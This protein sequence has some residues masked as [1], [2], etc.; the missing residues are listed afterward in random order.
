MLRHQVLLA[1][2]VLS[3]FF[4]VG[5]LLHEGGHWIAAKCFGWDTHFAY[6]QVAFYNVTDLSRRS[7]CIFK[8]AG[9]LVDVAFVSIGLTYFSRAGSS[10][11]SRASRL[12]YWI[13]TALL[14][15]AMRWL[16][17]PFQPGA[18]ESTISE[19]LGMPWYVIPYA[20]FAPACLVIAYLIRIHFR[21]GTL[22]P[23]VIGFGSGM[24]S[25]LLWYL[26]LG[27]RLLPKL[28]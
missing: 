24:S 20:L 17:A 16:K 18:D 11:Q 21:E 26:L 28:A 19:L 2:V 4:P 3:L 10:A 7:Y 8:L 25:F 23:L 9:P 5:M 27:P 12:R 15:S 13:A 14:L 6:S 1:V 22:V